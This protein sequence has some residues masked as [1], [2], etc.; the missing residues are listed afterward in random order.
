[1]HPSPSHDIT[2]V[3]W[4]DPRWI[5]KPLDALIILLQLPPHPEGQEG[6]LQMATLCISP[7][8][9]FSLTNILKNLCDLAEDVLFW[10][11]Q[12]PL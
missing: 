7:V 9:S 5:V 1:M 2:R 11:P 10:K 6:V 8:T 4:M 3:G 12:I